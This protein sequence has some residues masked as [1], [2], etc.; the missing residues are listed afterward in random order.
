MKPAAFDYHAPTTVDGVVELLG[1]HADA[2]ILAGG[3]SLVPTMNFR[4]ARPAVIVDINRIEDLDRITVAENHLDVGALVRHARFED[5]VEPGLLGD[6]LSQ[7]VRYVGH[8]PIRTRGTFVGSIA[9]ADP[10]AEWCVLARTLDATMVARG[11]AGTREIAADD[12]FVTMFSTA[13]EPDEF[14]TTVR[15]PR[16]SGDH[17][18]GFSE[19]ARRAGDFALVMALV[20]CRVSGTR[21]E[22]AAVGLGG[23]S[24]RPVRAPAAEAALIGMDITAPEVAAEAAADAAA[25][26]VTPL[27]DIHG[28]AAYRTDLIRA[29]VRRAAVQALT[30]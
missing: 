20:V 11:P 24:D 22:Q 2:K 3:Q 27:E 1:Q 8:H 6:L 25:D 17:R 30:P 10:A 12:F 13:L 28:S 21:I 14:L 26:S 29:T 23:V 16:L 4:L 7:V 15:V 18:A 9:H 5:P 19:F